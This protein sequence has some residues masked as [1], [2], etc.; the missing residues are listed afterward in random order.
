M[1]SSDPRTILKR[2]AD[3]TLAQ[4]AANR[5]ADRGINF[6]KWQWHQGV[7]LHGLLQAFAT[8]GDERYLQFVKAWVDR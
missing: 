2:L 6:E 5:H 1:N 3:R 4:A 7:A 8:L